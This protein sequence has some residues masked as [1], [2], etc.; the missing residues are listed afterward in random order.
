MPA[1]DRGK[2]VVGIGGHI[3]IIDSA[4]KAQSAGAIE[5]HNE[6][7]ASCSISCNPALAAPPK[8]SLPPSGVI[9]G[10][11]RLQLEDGYDLRQL[12]RRERCRRRYL[13][14]ANELYV[15]ANVDQRTS[16]I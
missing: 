15:A 1:N 3:T 9:T 7:V 6:P 4:D 8:C 10:K 11:I 5:V 16:K 2:A 12:E 13:R 14:T